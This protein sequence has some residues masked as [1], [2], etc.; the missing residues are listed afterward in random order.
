MSVTDNSDG[1]GRKRP[2]PTPVPNKPTALGQK[3]YDLR[4]KR[5]WAI[6][7]LADLSG[8]SRPAISRIESG[9]IPSPGHETLRRLAEALGYPVSVFLDDAEIIPPARAFGE[10]VAVPLVA[11]A[12]AGDRNVWQDTGGLAW[13]DADV[14]NRRNL[15]AAKVMGECLAPEVEPGDTVIFDRLGR[16]QDG[17]IAVVTLE[18]GDLIVRRY[19]TD[20]GGQPILVDNTGDVI[21]PDGA[22]IE[23]S[24]VLVIKRPSRKPVTV[25][26]V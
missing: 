17:E 24:V 18:T 12:H 4:E 8:V 2:G 5:G 7:R 21:R 14:G 15:L 23:G 22:T 11:V 20:S 1:R 25:P 16:P 10:V 9:H 6:T 13:V 3:L 26:A 19:G